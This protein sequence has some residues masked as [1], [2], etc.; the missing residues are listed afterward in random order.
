MRT[1]KIY[2]GPST[3][4]VF[5]LVQILGIK[6]KTKT[7]DCI[8]ICLNSQSD[9]DAKH[10]HLHLFAYGQSHVLMSI[11][12]EFYCQLYHQAFLCTVR[13][14]KIFI[15]TIL[16]CSFIGIETEI[17]HFQIFFFKRNNPC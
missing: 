14:I 7:H 15:L 5:R 3:L 10:L 6:K 16:F 8:K 4:F 11:L 2:L 9:M 17:D 12:E 13:I 1:V